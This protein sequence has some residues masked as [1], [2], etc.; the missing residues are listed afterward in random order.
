MIAFLLAGLACLG[1]RTA[2]DHDAK[3]QSDTVMT[4][5]G[6]QIFRPE[7]GKPR[8][9]VVLLHGSEG[10]LAPYS[11]ALAETLAK[12]GFVTAAFCWFDCGSAAAPEALR[13]VPLDRTL[14]FVRWFRKG[15]AEDVPLVLYGASR[16]GE[17]AVL[18]GSLV[19]HAQLFEG[20]AAHA[21]SDT[22]VAAYDRSTNGPFEVEDGFDAAWTWHGAVQ[23]GERALPHG[24]GPRIAIETYPGPLWLS[25]GEEDPL[26]PAARSHRLAEA[27]AKN[28]ALT[29]E[30]HIWPG[31]GHVVQ[32]R[33]HA[34]AFVE[35]LVTFVEKQQR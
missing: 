28:P 14:D 13:Q 26:W 22:V 24:S 30:L 16:G 21:A 20:L 1:T 19:A 25:H 23:Y 32:S 29:T 4:Y 10:G 33:V 35:S 18:L 8:A 5:P 11:P 17:Q 9:A 2:P 3:V 6:T 12:R 34:T 31:E 27:R 15:P 7:G